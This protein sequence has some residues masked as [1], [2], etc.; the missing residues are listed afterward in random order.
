MK[1]TTIGVDLAKSVFCVHGVDCHGKSV[2]HRELT[3]AKMKEFFANA[4][5]C[6]VGME[7]CGSAHY[8]GRELQALGHT[9]RL[10]AP[11]FVR[12]YR[13]N[14]KNDGNDAEAICE[15]VGRPNMRFVP[16][17]SVEQQAVL[18]I[19]G[20]RALLVGSRTA[21]VNQMRGLLAE[22]GIVAA[23]GIERLRRAMPGILEDAEN[24]LPMLARHVFADMAQQLH[25]LDARI[26]EYDRRLGTLARQ[27]EAAR[28]LMRI[29]GVGQ[30][31]ATAIL[32]SV[33]DAKVFA[34]GRQFAAWLGLVPRQYSSGGKSRL[35]RITKRGNVYL[36]TL[37]IHGARAALRFSAGRTDPRNRWAQA[38]QERR[39]Y[40]KAAVALAAKNARTIWAMLARGEPYRPA[41]A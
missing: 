39:G 10:M 11:Q 22:F 2:L 15:A 8:W 12:P 36:R 17:K 23:T 28:R 16:L 9:V 37:L 19:H 25:E 27:S 14:E 38:L 34:N 7:A 24:G 35:G 26:D 18:A 29:Q 31:S 4:P 3:R 30:I 40:N 32:A 20:A 33:G 13:K 21:L 6:V 41:T 1:V 5:T